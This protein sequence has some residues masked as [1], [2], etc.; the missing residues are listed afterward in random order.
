MVT[1]WAPPLPTSLWNAF[2]A[3]Q[4]EAFPVGHLCARLLL[5]KPAEATRCLLAHGLLPPSLAA[6]GAVAEEAGGACVHFKAAG[7]DG[8]LS[9][10]E[11]PLPPPDTPAVRRWQQC[12]SLLAAALSNV[13]QA[14]T[15][16][17]ALGAATAMVPEPAGMVPEKTSSEAAA[18]SALRKKKKRRP[19]PASFL[20][21]PEPGSNPE[22]EPAS[23]A[24]PK[25]DLPIKGGEQAEEAAPSAESAAEGEHAE[26][27]PAAKAAK[28]VVVAEAPMAPSD[29][30]KWFWSLLHD[31]IDNID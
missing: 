25:A 14:A 3:A 22:P 29:A 6:K 7:F 4:R 24:D 23:D 1:P 9:K 18:P 16:G 21:E 26:G 19:P 28:A 15:D 12:Q 17:A 31:G 30:S 10:L 20:A 5:S 27:R 13:A 11:P 8:K 2:C